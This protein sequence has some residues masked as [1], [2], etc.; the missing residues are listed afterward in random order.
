M[1]F[2]RAS[3]C[4]YHAKHSARTS[5][6]AKENAQ[7]HRDGFHMLAWFRSGR[8]GMSQSC[9]HCT[10]RIMIG[11]KPIMNQ[12]RLCKTPRIYSTG[13]HCISARLPL[14]ALSERGCVVGGVGNGNLTGNSNNFRGAVTNHQPVRHSIL[15]SYSVLF[16]TPS[17]FASH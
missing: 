11:G 5:P 15:R 9:F 14:R 12:R 7:Y 16:K 17:S 8:G 3:N 1:I 6:K 4:S 13:V 2:R 10:A